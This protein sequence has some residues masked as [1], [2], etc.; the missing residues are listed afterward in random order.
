VSTVTFD[1][2]QTLNR[3][4]VL[5]TALN[6]F[7]ISLLEGD[8]VLKAC[9]TASRFT[10][11]N[12]EVV[13]RWAAAVFLDFFA[14][15]SNIDDVDDA[16]LEVELS[17]SRGKH[18]KWLSL[19]HDEGFRLEAT[20]YVREHGYNKG[21]PNLTMADF[22]HW[23]DE[24]WDVEICAETA[25]T[26][27]HQMGF[28]YRQFSKGIYFDGHERDDVVQHRK[29]YLVSLRDRMLTSP[30]ELAQPRTS[31]LRPIIR[32]FHDESTSQTSHSTGQMDVTRL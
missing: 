18:P 14:T 30:A 28:S 20:K 9:D 25:R 27:L 17:S 16:S 21:T 23:V 26:W 6:I 19:I 10:G 12:S 29:E 15:T 7:S 5:S 13:R 32:I 8:S 11:F 1:D 4:A 22:I 3:T 31:T 24:E 2:A